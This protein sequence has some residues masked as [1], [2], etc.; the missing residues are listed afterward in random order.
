MPAH[1]FDLTGKMSLPTLVN[2]H[3]NSMRIWPIQIRNLLILRHLFPFDL[4]IS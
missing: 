3:E 1:A 2:F 4:L